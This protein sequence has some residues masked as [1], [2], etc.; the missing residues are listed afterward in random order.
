MKIVHLTWLLSNA[1]GGIPPVV[2]ALASEQRRAGADAVVA[3]I[4]DPG[5]PPLTPSGVPSILGK[6][7]GPL[8]LGF[9]P[10]LATRIEDFQPD[11]LHLHGLFTWS[12][13]IARSWGRK[14]GRPVVIAPHGMVDPWALSNSA[15]K[16]RVF[17][18]LVEDDNL[19][20]AA[21]IHALSA[22][23]AAHVR[24]LG[25]K[26]PIALLPNGFDVASV[27]GGP[28]RGGSGPSFPKSGRE[29]SFSTW[30]VY[31]PRKVSCR[32][33]RPGRDCFATAAKRRPGGSWSSPGRTSWGSGVIQGHV[34]TLGIDAHVV[35]SGALYGADKA[36]ILAATDIFVLP[37]FSEG[38]PMALLEA[39][40]WGLPVLAT[41]ACNID[42]ESPGAGL[43]CEPEPTSIASHLGRLMAMTEGERRA[44]GS[45]GR[46][47]V[48]SRYAWDRI[49]ADLLAVYGWLLGAAPR[50]D[51]V[52]ESR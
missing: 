10:G 7:V 31:I 37:S 46:V 4:D 18:T 43:L 38:V 35:L 49:A 17:G 24:K 16:K 12:S 47:E 26:C 2:A 9:A 45:R 19:A 32:S 44:M 33:W 36:A 8:A 21:C 3:G 40:A 48:E 11:V 34:R 25:L 42:V 5:A 14:H 51:C 52:Q 1:G 13:Q 15:W 30:A 39:M 27:Q 20:R 6:S 50:P 22:D 23:E 29:G 28:S 41:R